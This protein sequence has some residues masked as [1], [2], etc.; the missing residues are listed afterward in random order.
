[1][2]EGLS[3]PGR[4]SE[5]LNRSLE[6]RL[7]L[8]GYIEEL[9]GRRWEYGEC[10]CTMAVATWIKKIIGID[11]LERYRGTYHSPAEAQR[12]VTLAGG[13]L[14]TL[15]RRFHEAG[16]MP[17]ETF[18]DG[19]VAAVDPG[20]YHRLVLQVVGSILAIRFGDVWVC[21]AYRGII[22]DHFRVIQ[23]WRL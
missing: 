12:T 7:A 2:I 3:L 18:E 19:D 16:L 1:M 9:S 6:K 21:K 17:T 14:P 5:Q 23:G 22:G 10:D 8:P 15:E 11:P 13:F 20:Q 4:N